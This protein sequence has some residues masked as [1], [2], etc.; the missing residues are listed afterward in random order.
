[1]PP[2]SKLKK[3]NKSLQRSSSQI[4]KKR[5]YQKR[6]KWS[7]EAMVS[8][9]KAVEDSSSIASAAKSHSVPRMTLQ[10]R[11]MGK[12]VHSTKPGASPYLNTEEEKEL[13]D[14][15]SVAYGKNRAQI[16]SVAEKA[17]RDKKVLKTS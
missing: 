2:K 15:A 16:M 5:P 4:R 13:V 9:M 10:D 12:V 6:M 17:A 11:M 3:N 14:S 1:M 8:A 7:A